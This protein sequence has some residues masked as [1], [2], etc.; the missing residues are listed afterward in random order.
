[1]FLFQSPTAR[2]LSAALVAL[3]LI[4]GTVFI[5]HGAQKL[6]VFGISGVTG[7]FGQMGVP[8]PELVAPMVAFLEFFGGIALVLG[9]ATRLVAVGLAVNMLAAMV[10]VHL[11]NG[12]FMPNG[13][14]FVL[15]LF[16][17]M[18]FLT[19]AGAGDYSLDARVLQ[20]AEQSV[21]SEPGANR[22][23]RAA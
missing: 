16:G 7:A 3:R 8:L 17:A 11:P 23:R 2:Q 21:A 6:F 18:A 19:I 12:F 5:A 10:L 20:R 14:E 9:A 13:V 22:I 15:T 4:V 1:M